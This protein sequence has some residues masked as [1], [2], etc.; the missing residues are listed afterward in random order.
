MY[1]LE[2]QISGAVGQKRKWLDD[3]LSPSKS[4]LEI[5]NVCGIKFSGKAEQWPT[6]AQVDK[7]DQTVFL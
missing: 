1:E 3:I 6:K 2:N 7:F 4:G 5:K